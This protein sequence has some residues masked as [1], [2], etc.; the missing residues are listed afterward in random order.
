MT[1]QDMPRGTVR[2]RPPQEIGAAMEAAN[3]EPA[4]TGRFG[5]GVLGALRWALGGQV[6]APVTAAAPL[7]AAGPTVPHLLDELGAARACAGPGGRRVD[8][9]YARGVSEA[10]AW[11]CGERDRPPGDGP[12]R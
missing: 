10:L 3:A 1:V 2:V 8:P 9:E 5:R 12:A 4:C 6:A 11:V 7:D